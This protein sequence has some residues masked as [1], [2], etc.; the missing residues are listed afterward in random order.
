M[1]EHHHQHGGMNNGSMGGPGNM[2]GPGMHGGGMQGGGAGGMQ[3]V[4][5]P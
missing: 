5:L 1:G 2:Q 3:Q 4:P